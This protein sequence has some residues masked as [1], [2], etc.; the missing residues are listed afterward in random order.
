MK[1]ERRRRSP[2]PR[3]Y[4]NNINGNVMQQQPQNA[5]MIRSHG[6]NNNFQ[7]QGQ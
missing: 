1:R 6:I 3:Q 5:G 7:N 4:G 2:P